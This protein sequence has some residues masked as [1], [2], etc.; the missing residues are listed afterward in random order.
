[1]SRWSMLALIVIARVSMGLQFQS[2]APVA[3]LL[4]AD[5]VLSYSQPAYSLGSTCSPVP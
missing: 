3:P 1:M 5:F 4:I 2:I